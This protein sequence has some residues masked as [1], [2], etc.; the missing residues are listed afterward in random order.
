MFRRPTGRLELSRRT[1]LAA[2]PGLAFTGV[3]HAQAT[4]L[5]LQTPEEQEREEYIDLPLDAWTDVFGRPT[6]KVMID[7]QGPFRFLVDTGSTTSVLA[8]RHAA[9]MKMP[10]VGMATVNGTTGT[11]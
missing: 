8:A 3:A 5:L 6:A 11:A 4:G 10:T 2:A 9:K 7:G 1:L